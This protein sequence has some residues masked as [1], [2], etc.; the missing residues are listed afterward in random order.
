MLMR[1]VLVI[2]VLAGGWAAGVLLLAALLRYSMF[3]CSANKLLSLL[4]YLPGMAL[5][6]GAPAVAAGLA[7]GYGWTAATWTLSLLAAAI[8]VVVGTWMVLSAIKSPA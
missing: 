1:C 5:L 2:A 6:P 8:T 4:L 3:N 7:S